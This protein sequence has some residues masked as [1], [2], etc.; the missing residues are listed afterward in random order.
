MALTYQKR[1]L[2]NIAKLADNT[3]AAALKWHDYLVAN[4]INIL[5]YETIRTVEQQRQN[6]AN[7]ASQTMKSYHLVGQALDFVP[8]AN[9]ECM[10]NGY[11]IDACKKAIAYA[12]SLGFE[13]GG[14]WKG[15]VDKPHLQFNY[16]GYGTDTFGKMVS[17]QPGTDTA[18]SIAPYIPTDNGIIGRVRVIVDG[19]H[20]RVAPNANA[21]L[22]TRPVATKGELFDV[23]ANVNDWHNVGGANWVFG[24]N[25]QYLSLIRDEPKPSY[26][27]ALIKEGSRGDHVKS[28]QRAVGV[29]ADGIF[30]AK[31]KVALMA[32]QRARGLTADGI[33]GPQTWAVM[34]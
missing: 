26:P 19:L 3:K 16:K 14:D 34:L 25:G 6:V 9:G 2:D 31:T 5:I 30:G 13:W 32:W 8:V 33:V 17:S 4:N 21:P 27:G 18:N 10:W 23:Y 1:N 28:V 29:T 11:G 24:N 22:S 7:G 12:K 15:F 20:I